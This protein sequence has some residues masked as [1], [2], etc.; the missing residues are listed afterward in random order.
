M[1]IV[2]KLKIK[3]ETQKSRIEMLYDCKSPL[4]DPIGTTQ[5]FLPDERTSSTSER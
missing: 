1:I 4:S 3:E 2:C 5:F